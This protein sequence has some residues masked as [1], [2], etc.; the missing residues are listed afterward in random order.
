M[1]DDR[2]VD[3]LWVLF[4]TA[5]VLFM[6]AGFLMLESGAVRSKNAVNV[7]VKNLADFCVSLLMFWAFGFAL[8]FGM[9]GSGFGAASVPTLQAGSFFLF[10]AALCAATATIASGAVAERMSFRGY[11]SLTAL[12]AAVIYPIVGRWTWASKAGGAPGWLEE[13]GFVD[14]AGA[15]TVH[16]VGGWVALAAVI[17]IGPRLGRF[18][19]NERDFEGSNLSMSIGGVL[20]L[21]VGMVGIN[22]GTV[23]GIDDTVALVLLNT[24][25]GGASGGLTIVA[26]CAI[27]ASAIKPLCLCIGVLSGFVGVAAAAAIATPG[28]AVA[29]GVG[30]ALFS[31]AGKF[32]LVRA[33]IDDVVGA[34]PTHL[35]GGIC[36]TL[37]VAFI[38]PIGSFADRLVIQATGLVVVGA[39][40]FGLAYVA[41][42]V[43]DRFTRLRVDS[44]A[45]RAGLNVAE[46]DSR[47]AI[48]ELLEAMAEQHRSGDF[49]NHVPVRPE[50]EAGVVA[51][52]YNRVLKRVEAEIAAREA[53]AVDLAEARDVAET[54]SRAK[55]EFLA[56]MSHELRTPMNG[57]LG[58]S[59]VLAETGL[60]DGQAALVAEIRKSGVDLAE[61]LDDILV[62]ASN[63]G[64]RRDV[65]ALTLDRLCRDIDAS[66]RAAATLKGLDFHIHCGD[67]PGLERIGNAAA[68]ER[69]LRHLVENAIKFTA[70]GHVEIDVKA[71]TATATLVVRDTGRGI[72]AQRREALFEAFTQSDSS[73]TRRYG[74][75]GLGLAVVHRLTMSLGGT[76]EVESEE[77]RGTVFVVRLP[78]PL[79]ALG[80]AARA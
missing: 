25:L 15:T 7:A 65:A 4:C 11:L 70:E 46:N 53:M 48:G 14:F 26:I 54:A 52:Q 62:I 39:W 13:L 68:L 12:I 35:F 60:D 72:P 20:V 76:V 27:R 61:T 36:G 10:Q 79:A 69:I 55:S 17:V 74:G 2:L 47:S 1:L 29:L 28:E 41:L 58:L 75:A 40:S 18:G 44:Q 51:A 21:W 9:P 56:V 50:E 23:L 77:G 32:L 34:V 42:T 38:S 3:P 31:A 6:Q 5:L 66:Y 64:D 80:I 16:T 19:A 63:E 22:G 78:C 57:V 67:P 30:G 33:W 71:D 49:S 8:M 43:F 45:E 59:A 37:A 73:A 24:L